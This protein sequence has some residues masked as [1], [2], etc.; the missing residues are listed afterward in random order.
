MKFGF[1]P[2]EGGHM[3]R[4]ALTEVD[5]AE[6][7][8]FDSVWME[9]HHGVRGHYWPSPL[10]VL[11]GFATRTSRLLLGTDVVVP[12]FYHPVR[13]A[14]DAAMVDVLSGGR[15]VVRGRD[16]VP[17]GRVRPLPHAAREARGAV[18]GGARASSGRCGPRTRSRIP[19]P[20]YPLQN[21]RLEPK[22]IQRPHPPIWIGGWGE[23][24]IRRAARLADAWVPGPTAHLPKLLD[25]KARY[26]AELRAAGRPDPLEWP[27]TRDTV[28]ADTDAE[29]LELAERHLMVNYRDEY[30][31]GRW[32]HPLI[33]A[34]DATPVDQ[35]DEIGRTASSS[36]GP[37]GAGRR[38]AASSRS[39]ERPT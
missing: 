37:S 3:A 1:I 13:A 34:E 8:G 26:Q 2:T 23:L 9:E 15:F 36:A 11:A 17:A 39:S 31:G 32:K 38:S 12:P 10:V 28:I 25:G 24:M 19:G 30:G 27:L 18:R 5:R 33:G 6:E 16:R 21:A 22:P 7:L 35:L 20:H 29:A 14:E 4:E